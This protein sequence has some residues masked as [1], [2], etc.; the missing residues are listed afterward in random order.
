LGRIFPALAHLPSSMWPSH[1]GCAVSPPV[2]LGVSATVPRLSLRVDDSVAPLTCASPRAHALCCA[3]WCVGLSIGPILFP[4]RLLSTERE[5]TQVQRSRTVIFGEIVGILG[6][7]AINSSAASLS[8]SWPIRSARRPVRYSSSAVWCASHHGR[9][10]ERDLPPRC[11][12]CSI[13]GVS[14][15]GQ[16]VQTGTQVGVRSL[17]VRDWCTGSWRLL[18]RALHRRQAALLSWSGFSTLPLKVITSSASAKPLIWICTCPAMCRVAV[19][20]GFPLVCFFAAVGALSWAGSG[21]G[22]FVGLVAPANS[23]SH[24]LHVV[25]S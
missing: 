20:R 23:P 1:R 4:L 17:V 6:H 15:V 16:G 14:V 24:P 19:C 2:G 12:A 3:D 13:G 21:H 22:W 25:P 5:I 9:L 18:T 10:A 11:R 8:T 7:G